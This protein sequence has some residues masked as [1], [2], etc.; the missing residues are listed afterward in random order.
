MVGAAVIRLGLVGLGGEDLL[1]VKAVIVLPVVG[2]CWVE[3]LTE[4]VIWG[5][6]GVRGARGLRHIAES[7]VTQVLVSRGSHC[8]STSE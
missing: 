5:C 4:D 8:S 1:Y 6:V 3:V 2:L 7:I